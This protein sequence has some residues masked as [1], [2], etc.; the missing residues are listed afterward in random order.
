MKRHL[1]SP[2]YR[3]GTKKGAKQKAFCVIPTNNV[4][5]KFNA[6][7]ESMPSAIQPRL[8]ARMIRAINWVRKKSN[9]KTS[10]NSAKSSLQ[11]REGTEK[12][13]LVTP[14]QTRPVMIHQPAKPMR[15]SLIFSFRVSCFFGFLDS[16]CSATLQ[17]PSYTAG[18]RVE[19]HCPFLRKYITIATNRIRLASCWPVRPNASARLFLT[20]STKKRKKA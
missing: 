3:S 1:L 19:R 6:M 20:N 4:I 16:G 17:L 5:V 7:A 13:P 14:S 11:I 9:R 12:V 15:K 8:N 18:E 2:D 10:S